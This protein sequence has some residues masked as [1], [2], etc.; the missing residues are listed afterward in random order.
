MDLFAPNRKEI[1]AEFSQAV[2]RACETLDIKLNTGFDSET[3]KFCE[4]HAK[5]E[6][7][8]LQDM[9]RRRLR[10]ENLRMFDDDAMIYLILKGVDLLY[11][12]TLV[13]TDVIGLTEKDV[14]NRAKC[15]TNQTGK[16]IIFQANGDFRLLGAAAGYIDDIDRASGEGRDCYLEAA[17]YHSQRKYSFGSIPI[18]MDKLASRFKR[19]LDITTQAFQE[20]QI[21]PL[22]KDKRVKF[23]VMRLG[24]EKDPDARESIQRELVALI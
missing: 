4:E 21:K 20:S 2:E 1:E 10:R 13:R 16:A 6:V 11:D 24:L 15:V 14:V 23:L 19:Y 9:E 12:G 18:L 5:D 17:T 22:T 8:L 3:E 7:P